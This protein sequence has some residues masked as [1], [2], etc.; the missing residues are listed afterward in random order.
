MRRKKAERRM[1]L[2]KK[3]KNFSL[4]V[5][6]QIFDFEYDSLAEELL[7]IKDYR[8]YHLANWPDVFYSIVH[9]HDHLK[10]YILNPDLNVKPVIFLDYFK[11][12]DRPW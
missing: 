11:M 4:D 5:G 12:I 8:R 3:K 10:I 7:L 9:E 2:L 1:K 6:G